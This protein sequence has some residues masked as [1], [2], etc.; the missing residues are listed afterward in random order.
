MELAERVAPLKLTLFLILFIL[1]YL[2]VKFVVLLRKLLI[3]LLQRNQR[4]LIQFLV[5]AHHFDFGFQLLVA[6]RR[7]QEIIQ[8]LLNERGALDICE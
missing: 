6:L 8:E 3:L 7:L 5:M 1:D 2:H 4:L